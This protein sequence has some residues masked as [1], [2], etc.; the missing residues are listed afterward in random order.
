MRTRVLGRPFT[1]AAL[2]ALALPA[3]LQAG[4]GGGTPPPKDES[5]V[6]SAPASSGASDPGAP[7]ADSAGATASQPP[8]ASAAPSAS[9]APNG[10]PAGATTDASGDIKPAGDDPWLAAHQMPAGDVIKTMRGANAKVQ[11]CWKAGL[12]RDPSAG[13]E[14]KI[15]FV[16]Q[17]DGKVRVWKD[18]GSSM[19]DE[20]VTNCVGGVVEKLKFPKQKSP[21][22]AWAVYTIHLGP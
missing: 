4:C 1:F 10:P 8:S 2:A 12:K 20:D 15:R 22:D 18:D 21:G 13:G 11:A 19:S 16:V 9:P 7:A 5:E 14:V 17:N 6:A 3:A